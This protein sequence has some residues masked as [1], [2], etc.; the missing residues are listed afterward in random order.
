MTTRTQW[1][2][3]GA[4]LLVLATLLGAGIAFNSDL[5]PVTVASKAPDFR[6][7]DLA[8][9][10]TVT[11]ADYKGEVV[12]LNIWATW[13]APCRAEMPSLERLHQE[14]KDRGL[15][16]V[17]VSIDNDRDAVTDFVK[18]FGLTFQ[19]LHDPTGRIETTYQTTG[20]PESFIIDRHGI[21]VKKLLSAVEWDQP[22]QKLIWDRLLSERNDVPGT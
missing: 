4:A 5:K 18:E 15:H 22:E 10:D 21:I 17:A 14:M 6:A 9:G 8:T 19:I 3:V 12:L 16:I 2:V 1:I 20:V 13:C 7:L 11:L